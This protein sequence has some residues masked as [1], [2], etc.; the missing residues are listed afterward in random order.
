MMVFSFGH[1]NTY[2]PNNKTT[3]ANKSKKHD[4]QIISTNKP[5]PS[6]YVFL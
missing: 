3:K 2:M 5:P 1:T 4:K 6:K